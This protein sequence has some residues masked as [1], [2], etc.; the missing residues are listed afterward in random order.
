MI[1]RLVSIDSVRSLV[2]IDE[3]LSQSMTLVERKI[4]RDE[5]ERQIYEGISTS[6]PIALPLVSHNTQWNIYRAN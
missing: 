1:T 4:Y 6:R 3:R 2:V 5:N